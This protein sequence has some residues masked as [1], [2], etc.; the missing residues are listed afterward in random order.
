M[1]SLGLETPSM[2]EIVRDRRAAE[3]AAT[4]REAR[5]SLAVRRQYEAARVSR[6]TNDWTTAS[7]TANSELRSSL[8]IMRVR[9]RQL[10]RDN[11]YIKKFLS[12][13]RTNI[14]GPK[15]ITLQVRAKKAD[16]SL[17][18]ELNRVVEEAFAEWSHKENCTA[19][20]KLDWLGAQRLF[21]TQLA[22]DGEV[23]VQKVAANNKFGFALKFIDVAWLDENYNDVLANGNRVLMSVEVDR[24]D[25]PVAYYLTQPKGDY[26][27]Q[28]AAGGLRARTRVPASEMIHCFVLTEDET[29]TRGVPWTHTAMSR[30]RMLHGYQEAEVVAARLEASKMGFFVPPVSEDGGIDEEETEINITDVSPGSFGELPPGYD[31]KMFDPKHPN[32]SYGEFVKN[33]LRGIAA[34]LDVSYFTLAS[35]LEAVNYSSA[36]I[37]LLEERDVWRAIQQ[38]CIEY[39]CREVYQSFVQSALLS[40]ALKIRAKDYVA[41][42]EPLFRGRGWAWVDPQKDIQANVTAL[43]NNLATHT[44][45][46]AEQGIDFVEHLETIKAERELASEYGITLGTALQ[47]PP[48]AE[49]DEENAAQENESDESDEENNG[50]R[51]S[52]VAD[53]KATD[54]ALAKSKADAYGGEEETTR[55]PLTLSSKGGQN[56]PPY[57]SEGDA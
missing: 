28:E 14:V 56:A 40:G 3:A 13:C 18:T 42:K 43:E 33:I 25:K 55:R 45:I 16:G 32:N 53:S 34:G 36:R 46:L 19:S 31:L 48:T 41:V 49:S 30:L 11:D 20:G 22:R 8:R 44:D 7:T 17:D 54:F 21:V 23:L 15:G 37:G 52:S 4:V 24:F 27:A 6:L 2:S 12:M 38:F 29:Q 35:D 51:R 39:F 5:R 47:S 26:L 9:S 57:S 1:I 10:A 50:V